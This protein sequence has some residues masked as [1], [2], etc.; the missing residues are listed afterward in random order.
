MSARK[1]TLTI[2]VL[3]REV[4]LTQ[5][6]V[7]QQVGVTQPEISMY[8]RGYVRPPDDILSRIGEVLR[9]QGDPN[10]LLLPY[11]EYIRKRLPKSKEG[12]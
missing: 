4:D 8:E 9:Y 1:A 10:D 7:A 3:R 11:G 12:F 6:E 5:I 2:Q